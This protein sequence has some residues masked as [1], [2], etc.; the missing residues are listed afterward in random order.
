[1][2]VVVTAEKKSTTRA[3]KELGISPSAVTKRIRVAERTAGAKLFHSAEEGLVLTQA[4][5]LL[6]YEARKSIERALL[7]EEKV[8]AYLMLQERHLLVGHSTYLPPRL[9]AVLIQFHFDASPPPVQIEHRPELTPF[10]VQQVLDGTL[11]VGFGFLPQ[12]HPDLA[13]RQLYEEPLVACLP[14][15]HPISA[16]HTIYPEDLRGQAFIAIGRLLVLTLHKL[17][18]RRVALAKYQVPHRMKSCALL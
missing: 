5:E 9:M 14:A 4:G 2:A 3:G 18:A 15:G 16:K 6:Y 8:S 13:V 11:H 12:E 10:V 17:R 7:G 1:M